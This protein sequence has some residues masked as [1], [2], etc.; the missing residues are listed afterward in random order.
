MDLLDETEGEEYQLVN[1]TP[2][3]TTTTT[4]TNAIKSLNLNTIKPTT[5]LEGQLLEILQEVL[6][7]NKNLEGQFEQYKATVKSTFY[8]SLLDNDDK[9]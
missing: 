9:R 3:N 4:A 1:K 2:E 5:D 6:E 7:R 8:N